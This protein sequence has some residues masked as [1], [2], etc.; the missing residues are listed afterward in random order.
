MRLQIL[1]R[2]AL[3]EPSA[4]KQ[5]DGGAGLR[6]LLPSVGLLVFGLLGLNIATVLS[7]GVPGHFVVIAA[8][9]TSVNDALALSIKAG[10]VFIAQ[11]GAS[12]I[13]IAASD[14]TDFSRVLRQAGAWAVFPAPQFLGCSQDTQARGRQ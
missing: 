6:S 8:P 2:A 14:R 12:N 4:H 11:G 3:A 7:D 13:F 1:T 9:G 10:G 5:N